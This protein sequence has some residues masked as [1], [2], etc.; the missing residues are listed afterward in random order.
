MDAKVTLSFNAEVIKQAKAYA[1]SQGLSL[2]RLIEL[3][4]QKVISTGQ[5]NNIEHIPIEDWVSMVAEG[6][7]EYKTKALSKKKKK[8]FYE[9]RK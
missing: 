8:E 2:S 5:H 6:P 1:E 3:L 9:S 7:A 4:L